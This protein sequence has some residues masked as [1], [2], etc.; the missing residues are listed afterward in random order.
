MKIAVLTGI[1]CFAA[2]LYTNLALAELAKV[3]HED[4][5]LWVS[6]ERRGVEVFHYET[7]PDR[8]N[9]KKS[10]N[11]KF[12][13]K[14]P[15][16][17]EQFS[18]G[19]YKRPEGEPGY[20]R[21]HLVPANHW[22]GDQESIDG[23]MVVSN[24][25]P[26]ARNMNQ[27]GAWKR[28]EV[29]TECARDDETLQV[30]GGTIWGHDEGND[31]FLESHGVVTPDGFWKILIGQGRAIGWV[32]PNNHDSTWSELDKM[33]RPIYEIEAISGLK[34]DLTIDQKMAAPQ[35]SWEIPGDCDRG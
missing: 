35:Q 25:L 11:F 16:H 12:D 26:Q 22:D 17:C 19:T 10:H 15:D 1:T 9:F 33:I 32:I 3:E 20:D 23:T 6:C 7:E 5:T 18:K 24:M 27:N 30:W 31:H 21:G 34:F 2:S 4:F 28:T 14:L 8:A 29:I 13:P